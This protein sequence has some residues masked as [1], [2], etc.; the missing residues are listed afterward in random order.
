M[1]YALIDSNGLLE[2]VEEEVDYS[3]KV[4][5]GYNVVECTEDSR[6]DI[7]KICNNGVY[8]K[9]TPF[10]TALAG[11]WVL[12]ENSKSALIL[13]LSKRIEELPNSEFKN[14]ISLIALKNPTKAHYLMAKL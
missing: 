11:I 13:E 8:S 5:Q 7:G 4:A 2:S 9:P 3:E 12:K 6:N 14:V 1:M 10:H